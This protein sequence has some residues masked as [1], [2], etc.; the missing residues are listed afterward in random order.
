[1]H[2]FINKEFLDYC[3]QTGVSIEYAS[4]NAPQQIGVSER[5]GRT[6]VAM[7][8]CTIAD[9]GLPKCLWG[10]LMFAVAFLGNR[11]P[12]YAIGMQFPHVMLHGT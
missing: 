1:M 2:S 3:L 12:H 6:L 5:V 8:W 9:S 4:T 10:G 11:A 7:V